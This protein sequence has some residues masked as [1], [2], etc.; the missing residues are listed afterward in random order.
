MHYCVH[1]LTKTL[2]TKDEI[3]EIMQPY[4][5]EFVYGDSD[6]EGEMINYPTFTWD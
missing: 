1:L 4:N 2:P 6:D 3:A 5:S